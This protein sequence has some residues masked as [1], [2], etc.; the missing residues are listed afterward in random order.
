MTTLN[1]N[2]PLGHPTVQVLNRNMYVVGMTYGFET[3]LLSLMRMLFK[4]GGAYQLP[5][6]DVVIEQFDWCV[7][8]GT[9]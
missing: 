6:V 4:A 3:R 1:P 5:D 9:A 2:P 8:G 7:W